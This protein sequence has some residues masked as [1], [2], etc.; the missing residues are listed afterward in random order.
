M[1]LPNWV[2]I[3]FYAVVIMLFVG[4]YARVRIENESEQKPFSNM[5]FLTVAILVNDFVS[6][7]YV[8]EGFPHWLVVVTTY[9]NFGL[10]TFMGLVWYHLV[11]SVLSSE[12]RMRA[13][14]LDILIYIVVGIAILVMV[15]NPFTGLV[16]TF[17]SAEQYHRGPAFFIPAGA[18]YLSIIISELFLSLRVRSLG[19]DV[20]VS[21]LLFPLPPLIGG[22]VAMFL[23]G[24]P[25]MPLGISLSV[26]I[27]FTTLHTTSLGKDF[28]TGL[29]NRRR[30]DE[31]FEERISWA[32]NGR[33]LIALLV[34]LDDFKNINDTLGHSTGDIALAATADILRASVR[35]DDIVARIGGDEF[36]ILLDK[37]SEEIAQ[38]VIERIKEEVSKFNAQ[39][40]RF[41]LEL[42][43]GYALYD[44]KQFSTPEDYLAHVDELMYANKQ[45]RKAAKRLA[46]VG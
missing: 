8:I 33:S 30:F 6:R 39:N 18:T 25:W 16:F 37:A 24:I 35:E 7:M 43:I 38:N 4:I 23:Y 28:L 44:E 14:R 41:S 19:R 15:A 10:L 26:V 27:L 31:L 13:R 34:D 29:S 21:F 46:A 17:D 20:F 22:I 9:L 11:R 42:S 2:P 32:K 40:T 12:E 36:I 45:Q 1:Q 5:V 3:I